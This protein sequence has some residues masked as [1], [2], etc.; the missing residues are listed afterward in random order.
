M[1]LGYRRYLLCS[2]IEAEKGE[3]KKR[4]QWQVGLTGFIY[5]LLTV[6]P[7]VC[8]VGSKP[9]RTKL[10]KVIRPVLKSLGCQ[11]VQYYSLWD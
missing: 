3:K 6:S 7:C 2:P 10:G 4:Q 1:G 5:F 9:L 11:I 8:Y